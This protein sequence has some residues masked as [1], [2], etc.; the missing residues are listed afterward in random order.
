MKMDLVL[1]GVK[2]SYKNKHVLTDISLSASSGECIGILGANGSGKSTLL[3]L[4]SG[5]ATADGGSFFYKDVNL[6]EKKD[7]TPYV[8]YVPQSNPLVEELDA[9]DNLR[10][11][12]TRKQIHDSMESG[13]LN[14]LGI[15]SFLKTPVKKMSGGMQKRLS[16]ACSVSKNPPLMLLDEPSSALDLVC[17]EKLYSYYKSF[18]DCG[19]IILIVTHDIQELDFCTRTFVLKNGVLSPYTYDGN[20]HSLVQVL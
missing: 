17:K 12:Y 9:Y 10:L 13:V 1:S 4:L 18:L 20:I 15:K 11:W 2:K 7:K 16:I 6:F 5:V 19:G 3:A 14:I 8:A